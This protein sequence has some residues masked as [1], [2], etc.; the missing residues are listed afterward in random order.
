MRLLLSVNNVHNY[1]IVEQKFN[2]SGTEHKNL[3]PTNE[4]SSCP[5]IIWHIYK[6]NADFFHR[7]QQWHLKLVHHHIIYLCSNRSMQLSDQRCSWNLLRDIEVVDR[8]CHDQCG[9]LYVLKGSI[10]TRFPEISCILW[11]HCENLGC[12]V[13]NSLKFVEY[14]HHWEHLGYDLVHPVMVVLL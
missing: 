14:I 10:I 4:N 9:N 3:Q 8:T 5:K 13:S 11:L 6:K 12:L 7:T 1:F 2:D